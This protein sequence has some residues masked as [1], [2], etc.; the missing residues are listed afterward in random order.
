MRYQA[1]HNQ[2]DSQ[3]LLPVGL[4]AEG[5]GA[6]VGSGRTYQQV[7]HTWDTNPR[8]CS[9]P[10]KPTVRYIRALPICKVAVAKCCEAV[11]GCLTR[12]LLTVAGLTP[13]TGAHLCGQP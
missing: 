8:V 3:L 1:G 11:P 2:H 4:A 13:R 10:L 5:T 6:K 9:P 12:V 7:R